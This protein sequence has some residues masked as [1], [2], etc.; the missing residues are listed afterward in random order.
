MTPFFIYS[1]NWF[2][3]S[4][5]I[6]PL[7][8]TQRRSNLFAALFD[9][10]Y[11]TKFRYVL[12]A[13]A[14]FSIISELHYGTSCYFQLSFLLYVSVSYKCRGVPYA[15]YAGGPVFWNNILGNFFQLQ[16]KKEDTSH[17]FFL[18]SNKK[19]GQM[20]NWFYFWVR[21]HNII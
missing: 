13:S 17:F 5:S 2:E 18:N 9:L 14:E 8:K 16:S 12:G 11:I 3:W 6:S 4:F 19:G 15:A 21:I 20:N 10:M 7:A 1:D